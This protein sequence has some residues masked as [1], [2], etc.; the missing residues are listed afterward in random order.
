MKSIWTDKVDLKNPLA[1]Y[2]RPQFKRDC[3]QSLNGEFEYH[4]AT[5]GEKWI[6]DYTG[7]IIVPFAVESLLSG[8]EKPLRPTDRLWYRKRFTLNED[9]KGKRILLNFEAVDWQCK[10]YINKE[11]VG[12]HTGGYCEFSFDITDY[13]TD[14]ENVLT[15]CVYDPTESGWQQRGKQDNHPHG[16]WY[17]AT[18]GIWQTVWL[19]GV[20]E[21]HINSIKLLPDIDNSSFN[22]KTEISAGT[23]NSLMLYVYDKG[24]EIVSAEISTDEDIKL[25]EDFKLWSPEEPNLYDIELNLIKDGKVVD[26]VTSYFGMRKFGIGKDKFGVMRL[27]LNNK[28]YFQRGLLDQGYWPDGGLTPPCDE[29]MI[30]DIKEMKRLGFNMLRKHI[31]LESMR[32]YY[33]CDR[34]GMIVWQDMMSGGAYIGNLFAGVMPNIVPHLKDDKYN[35]FKREKKDARDDYKRELGEM[36]NQLYNVVSIFCWVPFNEGWGQF[37]SLKICNYVKSMDTSRVVDHAS[38]WYDQKGGD[39][40]SLHRYVFPVTMPKLDNKRAFVITEFGGYQNTYTGHT[41]TDNKTFG[42]YLKFK[43]KDTLTNAYKKLHEKQIIPLIDKGLCGTVYTQVSDVE[44]EL[45]GI[46]TYDRAHL[47]IDEETIIA[48]NKKLVL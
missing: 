9:L 42:L 18:S 35:I 32:W 25:P 33:H 11:L 46:Y 14:G 3:W 12:K 40:K 21:T 30:F 4:I 38:G 13:L 31:K 29:A 44:N 27:M 10:V 37:D 1:D 23:Y 48:I 5:R 6:E 8:V 7:T 2:P 22:I 26:C 34:L 19:E 15:V 24:D 36:I 39:I 45:N 20:S 41:W 16:F 47:K 17:T 28:P 43:N